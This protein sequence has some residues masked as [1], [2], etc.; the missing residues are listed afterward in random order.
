MFTMF[1]SDFLP[2]LQRMSVWPPPLCSHLFLR[3]YSWC[4]WLLRLSVCCYGDRNTF[5]IAVSLPAFSFLTAFPVPS[6]F[7]PCRL[8]LNDVGRDILWGYCNESA[9]VSPFPV[10]ICACVH[11]CACVRERERTSVFLSVFRYWAVSLSA[12]LWS[13]EHLWESRGC[14]TG[15]KFKYFQLLNTLLWI[16]CHF[17]RPISCP[18][19]FS[20]Y[21]PSV[22]VH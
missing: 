18:C 22:D 19:A 4:P 16:L 11:V 9:Q 17:V 13:R 15:G 8:P 14:P 20:S 3:Y 1:S 6:I 2:L 10:C 5:L 12:I 7:G 21:C